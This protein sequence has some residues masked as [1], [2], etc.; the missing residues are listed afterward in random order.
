MTKCKKKFKCEECGHVIE[1]EVLPSEQT[2]MCP[3]CC[4]GLMYR[5]S[6]DK[7][8]SPCNLKEEDPYDI[9]NAD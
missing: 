8:R 3:S 6:C 7:S 2:M 9:S 5:L 1:I 4:D